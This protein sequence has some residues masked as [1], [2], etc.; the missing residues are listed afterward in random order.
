MRVVCIDD[1]DL[2][3]R[4]LE[5]QLEKSSEMEIVGTFTN[6]LEGLDFIIGNEVDVVFLDID[7]SP[8]N[9]MGIAEKILEKLPETIIVFVTAYESYAVEAFELDAIDYI[10]KPVKASRL[11]ATVD[12]IHKQAGQIH[13]A[14]IQCVA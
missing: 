8:I 11:R 2:A 4:L 14:I 10:L 3:L 12:R 9:G 7:M 6:P 1:E 13:D 5:R